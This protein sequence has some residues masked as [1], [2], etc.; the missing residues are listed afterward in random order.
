MKK[1]IVSL[2]IVMV[3]VVSCVVPVS[4]YDTEK[5]EEP[6]S[7]IV[8]IS[9]ETANARGFSRDYTNH[10]TLNNT[11]EVMT[12]PNWDIWNDTSVTVTFKESEGPLVLH[13]TVYYKAD[14]ATAWTQG[15]TG[16]LR[17]GKSLTCSIP[18]DYTIKVEAR[19]LQGNNG[20][21]TLKV[22]LS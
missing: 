5:F 9:E 4:A 8:T 1:N 3:L 13:V 18:Q 17:V 19:S 16:T 2:F 11:V 15:V 12:D 22:A 6:M 20:N 14:N 7:D 21:A 10:Y